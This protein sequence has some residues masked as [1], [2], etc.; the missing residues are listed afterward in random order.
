[1]IGSNRERSP[2][3]GALQ[4]VIDALFEDDD[5]PYLEVADPEAAFKVSRLQVVLAAEAADLPDELLRVVNLL[6]PGEYT[7]LRLTTQLNSAITGHA[8][9][10]VFGTVS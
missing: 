7:R 3:Y 5:A 2:H 10:Q 8:W 9:G 6:P 4:K 1:M